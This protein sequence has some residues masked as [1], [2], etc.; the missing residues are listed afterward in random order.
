VTDSLPKRPSILLDCDPGHDDAAAI[1]VA[2]AYT[3]LLAITTVG[4]NAPLSQTTHNA[5]LMAQ[6]FDIECPVA[7]GEAD[8]LSG[9]AQHAPDIHGLSGLDGPTQPEV[10][11]T[12]IDMHAVD[13]I[14]ETTRANP[15][16]WIVATGPCTNV[17]RALQRAPRLVDDIAGISLMGGSATFGNWSA[18]AE[19]NIMFDPEAADIVFRCG[20]P[21]RMLG[22][23]A[24]HQVLVTQQHVDRLNVVGT[25][26]ARFMAGLYEYFRSTYLDFF[27]MDAAPLHD[28]CAVMAITH[29]HL[30]DL[31]PR[32]V[33]VELNGSHTRGMTVVDQRGDG[34]GETPNAEVAYDPDGAAVLRL[35]HG[36]VTL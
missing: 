3:N 34:I 2:R 12:T 27:G 32:H 30:F 11:R 26:R 8:P 6:L 29:P 16:M 35:V 7:A 9:P 33:V 17:A 13:V 23:N 36:A 15:G 21:I 4:G 1:V 10:T 5:L 28:P 31:R 25:D 22:L 20:A 19:F 24:T 14:I 18:S